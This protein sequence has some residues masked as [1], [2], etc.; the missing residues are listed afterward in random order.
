LTSSKPRLCALA[1][2]V[3]RN[4]VN[5]DC[6]RI[7]FE[8]TLDQTMPNAVTSTLF[9]ELLKTRKGAE[10]HNLKLYRI[11]LVDN[12]GELF[13]YTL[14]NKTLACNV[15]HNGHQN[16]TSVWNMECEW[17]VTLVGVPGP[18]LPT[19]TPRVGST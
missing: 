10:L 9:S 18:R 5:Y 12:I 17:N 1:R 11:R 16:S 13:P 7:W 14:L 4:G 3:S 19:P 15:W 6:Y 2:R 8:A